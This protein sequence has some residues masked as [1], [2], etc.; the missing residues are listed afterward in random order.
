MKKP[1]AR[2]ANEDYGKWSSSRKQLLWDTVSHQISNLEVTMKALY[3]S[4]KD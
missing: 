3:I 1:N 4:W 2:E